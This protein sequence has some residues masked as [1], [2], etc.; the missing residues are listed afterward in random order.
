MNLAL[1]FLAIVLIGLI[2]ASGYMIYQSIALVN[3]N[4]HKLRQFVVGFGKNLVSLRKDLDDFIPKWVF[5]AFFILVAANISKPDYASLEAGIRKDLLNYFAKPGQQRQFVNPEG[6]D[7]EAAAR[8]N[9]FALTEWLCEFGPQTCT[10][11]A[12]NNLE[13]KINDYVAFKIA[14]VL[15]KNSP[16]NVICIGAFTVW[17][18]YEQLADREAK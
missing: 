13:Y 8:A 6:E 3:E 5:I 1:L 12:L 11:M 18:C 15:I 16:D 7:D 2:A 9:T 10:N 4:K 14:S 17:R